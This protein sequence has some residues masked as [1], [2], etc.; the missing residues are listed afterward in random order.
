MYSLSLQTGFVENLKPQFTPGQALLSPGVQT[1][2]PSPASFIDPVEHEALKA[3]IQDLTEKLET[4]RRK[5]IFS[6]LNIFF[7]LSNIY[8]ILF[9]CS[10][11]SRKST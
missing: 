11:A 5:L 1:Q 8:F 10:E 2:R 3:Q 9:F 7:L 4:M 6:E